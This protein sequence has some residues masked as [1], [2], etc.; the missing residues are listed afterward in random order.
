MRCSLV[1]ATSAR[2]PRSH[3]IPRSPESLDALESLPAPWVPPAPPFCSV[4]FLNSD[5][6]V[7]TYPWWDLGPLHPILDLLQHNRT[8]H[9]T[10]AEGDAGVRTTLEPGYQHKTRPRPGLLRAAGTWRSLA[11]WARTLASS[12]LHLPAAGAACPLPYG[13]DAASTSG[14][15]TADRRAVSRAA[16]ASFWSAGRCPVRGRGRQAHQRQIPC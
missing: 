3:R 10:E 11:S 4:L 5:V 12:P 7:P 9:G 6:P 2:L 1:V 15:G 8:V 16:S 13:R 14:N